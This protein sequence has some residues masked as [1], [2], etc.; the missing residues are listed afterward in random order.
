M[1]TKGIFVA[2][3]SVAGIALLAAAL[4]GRSGG[5]VSADAQPESPT[6]GFFSRLTGPRQEMIV[7]PSGTRI[8]VR[9]QQGI[10]TEKNNSGDTFTAILDGPLT[11]SGKTLAPAGSQVEGILTDVVDSG[12]VE[13]RASLTMVL[14]HINVEGEEYTLSTQPMTLV[15]SSTRK[16]DAKIIGG[17]AAAGAVIGAIAGGGKGAAIGAAVGGGSGTGYVLATKGN[18]VAYGPE[19]RFT[20]VLTEAVDLPVQSS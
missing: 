7:V 18:P 2:S 20:F 4:T 13:G 10:S 1:T 14:R 6:Q 5:T 8:P 11:I 3:G 17:T 15:A 9:L 19:T 16:K 12:R